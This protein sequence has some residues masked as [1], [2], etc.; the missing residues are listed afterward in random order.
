MAFQA[1]VAFFG[2]TSSAAT[3]AVLCA[4][5]VMWWALV[6]C[7]LGAGRQV[8]GTLQASATAKELKPDPFVDDVPTPI[9]GEQRRVEAVPTDLD[10]GIDFEAFQAQIRHDFEAFQAQVGR[11][12]DLNFQDLGSDFEAF[13]AQIG[14]RCDLELDALCETAMDDYSAKVLQDLQDEFGGGPVGAQA[15]CQPNGAE[16][17]M[18]FEAFQ[19]NAELHCDSVLEGMRSQGV[20]AIDGVLDRIYAA[21]LSDLEDG[22]RASGALDDDA[23]GDYVLEMEEEL[24]RQAAELRVMEAGSK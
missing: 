5:V 10:L 24:S 9:I 17:R 4:L 21:A 11:R 23:Q 18:D 2:L 20:D 19:A 8:V 14:R 15:R 13:Q 12:F 22:C 3:A 6:L 7:A 1:T 16:L